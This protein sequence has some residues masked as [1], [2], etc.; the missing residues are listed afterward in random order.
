MNESE[1]IA[2]LLKQR[3]FADKVDWEEEI[4]NLLLK[5]RQYIEFCICPNLWGVPA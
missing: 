2:P 5:L 1:V 4:K 3:N